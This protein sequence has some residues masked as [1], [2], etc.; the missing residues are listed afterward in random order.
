MRAQEI[1]L[2][3]GIVYDIGFL[4]AFLE[5]LLLR[6]LL[7]GFYEALPSVKQQRDSERT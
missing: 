2:G 3:C 7:A 4:R 6:F 5:L 1:G